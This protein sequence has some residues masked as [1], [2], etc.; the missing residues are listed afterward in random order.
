MSDTIVYDTIQIRR[1]IAAD[2]LSANPVLAQGE[3]G[4]EMDT[5]K[6][7]IGDGITHWVSL[8]YIVP[9]YLAS[10]W[11]PQ[12]LTPAYVSPS[13]FSLV[14]NYLY[15]FPVGL[16]VQAVVT[17]GTITGTVQSVTTSG[18][19]VTLTT[20]TVL[21]DAGQLDS[22]LSALNIGFVNPGSGSLPFTPV[23][24]VSGASYTMQKA[25]LNKSFEC[26]NASCTFNLI[27]PTTIPSGVKTW[28]HNTGTGTV[29]IV[30][31]INGLSSIAL[32]TM[33]GALLISDGYSWYALVTFAI[34]A[35]GTGKYVL[36]SGATTVNQALTAPT[37]NDPSISGGTIDGATLTTAVIPNPVVTSGQFTSPT[38]T[39][40]VLKGIQTAGLGYSM[41]TNVP[42]A[43]VEVLDASTNKISWTAIPLGTAGVPN[44]ATAVSGYITLNGS[45]SSGDLASDSSGNGQIHFQTDAVLIS[46]PFRVPIESGSQQIFYQC[47]DAVDFE[48]YISGYEI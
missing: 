13:S 46:I 6:L 23:Y 2:W 36:D 26:S 30:G 45:T 35:T 12:T 14:G 47:F 21:W 4:F 20:V 25:D 40:P 39:N 31:T 28:I 24:H 38:I 34:Q 17:A 41:Q 7:K 42:I 1:G 8:P 16:R 29:T 5:N 48:V 37:I 33:T 9:A 27:D 18:S 32:A 10:Q 19:P 43:P 11:V 22:G 3:M 44:T 15:L